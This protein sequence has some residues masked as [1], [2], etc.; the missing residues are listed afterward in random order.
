MRNALALGIALD[1]FRDPDWQEPLDTGSYVHALVRS[2][3]STSAIIKFGRY[4]ATIGPTEF[5]W[6]GKRSPSDLL[7]VGDIVY[8]K[9]Q[10]L[11]AD[12][13]AKVTLEQD[14]GTQGALIAVDNSTGDIKAMVGG[15]DFDES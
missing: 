5:A 13:T 3:S 8:V 7:S 12:G 10:S 2:V 4:L 14:S 6:T 1:A 9:V 11:V 15:R